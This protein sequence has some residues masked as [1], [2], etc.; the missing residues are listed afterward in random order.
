MDDYERRKRR[1]EKEIDL[2][3]LRKKED[4]RNI[5]RSITYRRGPG[6]L[7]WLFIVLL[8]AY[9]LYQSGLIDLSNLSRLLDQY[10]M[11]IF[12]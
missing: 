7:F 11:T 5:H 2:L 9:L 1:L 3:R 8:I 4:D 12:K 10:K 6:L